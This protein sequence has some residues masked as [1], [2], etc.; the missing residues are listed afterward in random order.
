MDRE[1]VRTGSR[2]VAVVRRAVA[3]VDRATVE[4]LESADTDVLACTHAES[5]GRN[6]QLSC[7][8]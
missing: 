3:A 7:R 1:S 6:D 4:L 8:R 2:A 5:A